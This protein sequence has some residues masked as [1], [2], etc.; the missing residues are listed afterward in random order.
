VLGIVQAC[1]VPKPWTLEGHFPV[2]QQNIRLDAGGYAI[3][4]DDSA[5]TDSA[6]AASACCTTATWTRCSASPAR[7]RAAR[8]ADLRTGHFAPPFV[9]LGAGRIRSSDSAR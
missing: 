9:T 6:T 4:K 7:P 5:L 1:Q 8:A 2:E 3:S